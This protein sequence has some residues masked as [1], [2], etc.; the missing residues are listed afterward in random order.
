MNQAAKKKDAV[1]LLPI[2]GE[3]AESMNSYYGVL[4]FTQGLYH[5]LRATMS[6]VQTQKV[7]PDFEHLLDITL[8]YPRPDFMDMD[9][10]E[11]LT[12]DPLPAGSPDTVFVKP[13]VMDRP[14]DTERVSYVRCR[15]GEDFIVWE[16]GPR[17]VDGEAETV[18]LRR[19]DLD[20]LAAKA[21]LAV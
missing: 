1:L 6:W 16:I 11:A 21:G 4:A 18:E 12:E 3:A 5:K 19:S 10:V 7:H 9:Q 17:Y 14:F 20:R 13:G 8:A 15:I 2:V